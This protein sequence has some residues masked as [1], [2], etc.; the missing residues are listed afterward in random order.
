[1]VIGAVLIP[2]AAAPKL[3]SNDLVAQMKPGSVLVDIAIDQGGCFEDSRPTT[4]ADPTFE[5]HNSVFYCVANMPGA[6]P[7]TSTYA[8][9]NATL[10]Y[11]VKLANLGWRD[12]LRQDGA[13][14]L[15]LNTYGGH[16][17]YGP[18]AE[19]HGMTSMPVQEALS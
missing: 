5:V 4:H 18:V 17:T 13:L 2:G 14:A 16:V 6:V 15:G 11:A 12:A 3:V 7:N 8:L 9:T 19:A 10:P 1:M